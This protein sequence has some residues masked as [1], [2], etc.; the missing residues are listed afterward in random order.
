MVQQVLPAATALRRM[1]PRWKECNSD[2]SDIVVAHGLLR[3]QVEEDL[4]VDG[5]IQGQDGDEVLVDAVRRLA[6]LLCRRRNSV[7]QSWRCT[8][9]TVTTTTTTT[10]T[11][12]IT[13]ATARRNGGNSTT[14]DESGA[15]LV[16]GLKLFLDRSDLCHKLLEHRLLF[17]T[18]L[19]ATTCN[20][21]SALCQLANLGLRDR[22]DQDEVM[23]VRRVWGVAQPHA[24]GIVS[25][26]DQVPD[27]KD[28][29]ATIA[30]T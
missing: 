10:M 16:G 1:Q 12:V 9:A 20:Q 14:G 27:A 19:R 25:E 22:S 29:S 5:A 2:A 4:D 7:R 21:P 11:A 28:S 18:E 15:H 13:T 3:Q 8:A 30:S 24:G 23:I 6:P 26:R 17:L